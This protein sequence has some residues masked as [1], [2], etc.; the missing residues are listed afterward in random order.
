MKV[1]GTGEDDSAP[2]SLGVRAGAALSFGGMAASFC[3]LVSGGAGGP[4]AWVGWAGGAA[5]GATLFGCALLAWAVSMGL[6]WP[7]GLAGWFACAGGAVAVTGAAAG[8]GA[9]AAGGLAAREEA[10]SAWAFATGADCGAGLAA[11]SS[12]DVKSC[13]SSLAV[14]AVRNWPPVLCATQ[15]SGLSVCFAL[16]SNPI[17]WMRNPGAACF[18]D[19]TVAQTLA[20]QLSRPSVMS[21]TS[22]PVAG[23]C[24]AASTSA[25]AIGRPSFGLKP[26][27]NRSLP[28]VFDE[29][30]PG[31]AMSSASAQVLPWR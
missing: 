21:T 28:G 22:R 2:G 8:G 13:F 10:R 4:T 12:T 26:A 14:A 25:A 20:L 23:V 24:L 9:T 30:S 5:P 3:M 31:L 17:T 29:S 16:A 19:F 18:S 1:T 6:G 27:P 7:G 11:I 15:A